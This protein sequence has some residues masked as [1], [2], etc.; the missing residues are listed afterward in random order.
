MVTDSTTPMAAATPSL[1]SMEVMWVAVFTLWVTVVLS[2]SCQS[3]VIRGSVKGNCLQKDREAPILAGNVVRCAKSVVQA[4]TTF[5]GQ[6]TWP[7]T[8]TQHL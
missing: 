3:M 1:V 5:N 7:P 6:P 2:D 4:Q 8:T